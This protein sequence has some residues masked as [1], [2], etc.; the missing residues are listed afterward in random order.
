MLMYRSY[1][2]IQ[3][4]SS[5]GEY[6]KAYG[7]HLHSP[8][9]DGSRDSQGRLINYPFYWTAF[10]SQYESVAPFTQY[11]A[12][13]R[14]YPGGESWFQAEVTLVGIGFNGSLT[15][16]GSYNW[17]YAVGNNG[18]PVAITPMFSPTPSSF[19]QGIIQNYNNR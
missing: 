10:E 2:W 3:T 7:L 13:F 11:S 6:D 16:L 1:Q 17:G 15:P 4:V 9:V 5:S 14:D 12:G 18:V 8:H 19:Q